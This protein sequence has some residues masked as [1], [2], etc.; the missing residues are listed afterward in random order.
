MSSLIVDDTSAYSAALAKDFYGQRL[1]NNVPGINLTVANYQSNGTITLGDFGTAAN[2]TIYNSPEAVAV[3]TFGFGSVTQDFSVGRDLLGT[4]NA[5]ILGN[6][7]IGSGLAVSGSAQVAADLRVAGQSSITGNLAVGSSGF[8]AGFLSVIQDFY[9]SSSGTILGA[10]YVG[11]SATIA[12][13]LNV[14]QDFYGSS[15]GTL[16]GALYVGS[17]STIAGSLTVLQDI[18][19]SSS[20]TILGNLFV[21]TGGTI[22]DSLK[23]GTNVAVGGQASITGNLSI[24]SCAT[25]AG[26]LWIGTDLHVAGDAT[27][28]DSLAV[29]NSAAVST[30]LTVGGYGSV[31]GN[32]YSGGTLVAPYGS[33]TNLV[34]ANAVIMSNLIVEGTTEYIN[35]TVSTQEDLNMQLGVFNS[36]RVTASDG[37]T[38]TL[39]GVSGDPGNTYSASSNIYGILTPTDELFTNTQGNTLVLEITSCTFSSTTNKYQLQFKA[40]KEDGS[41]APV[42]SLTDVG[43]TANYS[44]SSNVVTFSLLVDPSLYGKPGFTFN[45]Y[46]SLSGTITNTARE[47][48]FGQESLEVYRQDGEVIDL[49]LSGTK[50]A[51]AMS[52]PAYSIN[53]QALL[54]PYSVAVD[55]T[56]ATNSA[57]YLNATGTNTDA[58]GTWRMKIDPASNR[59]VVQLRKSGGWK[60]GLSVVAPS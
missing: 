36:R 38:Y 30:N 24:G 25:V 56:F 29:L 34:A 9:G 20:G 40:H 33:I 60:T 11:S 58:I 22:A 32:F 16:L 7:A 51:G 5:N 50:R 12:G 57:I 15:S 44:F 52:T 18:F 54:T 13:S 6:I 49:N 31:N 17:S 28:T 21:G 48:I 45:T 3:A 14:I 53:N 2:F 1:Y 27:I 43:L 39:D 55:T 46:S 37:L 10:L 19:G 26:S 35:T 4:R 47:M 42:Q 8:I 59:F 23:V 41:V